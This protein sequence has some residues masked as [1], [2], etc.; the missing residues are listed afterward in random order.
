[1]GPDTST[2]TSA[3]AWPFFKAL[4]N[5][6]LKFLAVFLTVSTILLLTLY[7]SGLSE[8][9][10]IGAKN[11][12]ANEQDYWTWETRTRFQKSSSVNDGDSTNNSQNATCDT[13]PSDVLSRVQIILKTSATENPD[14]V[15]THM[16]SV[17]RCISNL[18]VVSDKETEIHGHHVHDILADLPFS[19]R[20]Q[21]PEFEGYDALQR[22]ENNITGAAGWKLDR[23][24]FLPMV[25]RAKKVNPGAEWYV[26][27]E[28][29]TYFVWD[30]LFR[31]LEQFNSS[32]PLYMGS[33]A[34]GRDIDGKVIWFA[35]GG[36]GF[37]LSRAAVDTLVAREIGKYGQ[38]IGQSL[39]EQYMQAVTDDCCG[40]SVLGFVLYEKGI[41]LSGMWPMFNAHPLDSIPFG[42]DQHWCQPAISMHKSKLSDMTGLADWEDQRDRTKPLLYADLV[43]YHGLG[44]LPERK[45]WDNGAW[46]GIIE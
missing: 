32:I 40:D 10:S 21:I 31:M 39:S 19:S 5:A 20:N 37:V 15:N 1:M 25:E 4:G 45:G 9:I 24:K 18:L 14:R 12:L 34:P 16:A 11:E 27:L 13:F 42:D 33:P 23:F 46:G 6:K 17:T 29:D 26:F 28:T 22:G 41:E 38:F 30:N 8:K 43:D 36:S 3:T 7:S 35:Y 44:K 2:S